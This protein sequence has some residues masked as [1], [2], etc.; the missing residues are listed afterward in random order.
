MLTSSVFIIG[1]SPPLYDYLHRNDTPA[2]HLTDIRSFEVNIK[3]V[4]SEKVIL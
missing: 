4:I 2:L 1:L 3:M